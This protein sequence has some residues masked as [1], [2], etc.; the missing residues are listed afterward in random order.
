VEHSSEGAVKPSCL[1]QAAGDSG[2]SGIELFHVEQFVKEPRK[3]DHA[4]SASMPRSKRL[5]E[6]RSGAR[7][8][9]VEY[10]GF[11]SSP[12]A[13]LKCGTL[14]NVPCGT[15]VSSSIRCCRSLHRLRS[16]IGS[17]P[18]CLHA[19]EHLSKEALWPR[20]RMD[21]FCV[22]NE[23]TL[24]RF[25]LNRRIYGICNVPRGTFLAAAGDRQS[26]YVEVPKLFH[27][28]HPVHNRVLCS[29]D[30]SRH[31]NDQS[32]L[33]KY[34]LPIGAHVRTITGL[35]TSV[36][37]GEDSLIAAWERLDVR[38]IVRR[39]CRSANFWKPSVGC[40]R[41]KPAI[42]GDKARG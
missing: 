7:M 14:A 40:E 18:V 23:R 20:L 37:E 26:H 6:L 21:A 33:A 41:S 12:A 11:R 1:F 31:A 38:P 22:R 4:R 15:F 27:V 17:F 3:A 8:L 29:S 34:L 35:T 42:Q 25:D 19:L 36:A 32:A 10:Y 24:A 39:P 30:R 9:H 28:E 16:R 13:P 2:N 5:N